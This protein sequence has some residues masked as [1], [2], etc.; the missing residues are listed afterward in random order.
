MA[1]ELDQ[2]RADTAGGAEDDDRLPGPDARGS[3]KHAPRGQAVDDDRFGRGSVHS[4]GHRHQV[5][6]GEQD[7]AGP[8]TGLGQRRYALPFRW[9]AGAGLRDHADEVVARDERER[10]LVVVL[11]AAHLLL[12]E[13]DPRGLDADQS[14]PRPGRSYLAGA[15]LQ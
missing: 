9:R 8:A 12:G 4:V 13:R 11:A 1:G 3:V 2:G 15:D 14:L 10:R 6:G 7:V 5:S